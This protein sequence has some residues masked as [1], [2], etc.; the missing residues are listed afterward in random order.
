ME[1]RLTKNSNEIAGLGADSGN[2]SSGILRG[3]Y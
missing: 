2:L 3:D 1:R